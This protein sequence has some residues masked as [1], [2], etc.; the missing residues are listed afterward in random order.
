MEKA[1]PLED[2]E[3]KEGGTERIMAFSDGVFAIA[4]TLLVLD[5]KVPI[6]LNPINSAELASAL[7]QRWPNYLIL[8]ISFAT[9]LIMWVYH[10]NL[11][12]WA[13][14]AETSLLFGNGLLLLL[15]TIVPFPTALVGEYLTTPAAT[16]AC[17]TYAGFFALIDLSYNLLWWI[18][19]RQQ[20]GYRFERNRLPASMMISFLG[21]PC[22]LAATLAAFLSPI[23][24]L[25]ICCILWVVWAVTA[26]TQRAEMA[27]LFSSWESVEGEPTA[28]VPAPTRSSETS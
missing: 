28:A 26:H 17:A 15:V 6:G 20:P 23:L 13:K 5:L 8:V 22:Y 18:V 4:I 10:H 9:I 11:F 1:V 19:S 21:F 7:L 24:T 27:K 2:I 14:K 12:Q 16:A 25:V 3:R